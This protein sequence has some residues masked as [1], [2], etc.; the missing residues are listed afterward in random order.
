MSE[1]EQEVQEQETPAEETTEEVVEQEEAP[2]GWTGPSKEE[3]ERTQQY[4]QFVAQQFIADD[5]EPD[6]A[7]QA[8]A[9]LNQRLSYAE[10]AAAIAVEER[11]RAVM[12]EMFGKLE[13]KVGSFDHELAEMYAERL[14]PKYAS[15]PRKAVEE[16]AKMAAAKRKADREAGIQEYTKSLQGGGSDDPDVTNAGEFSAEAPKNYDDVISKWEKLAHQGE[17]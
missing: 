7:Q 6:P 9:H 10:Q 17:V 5:D 8:F 4:L 15:N 1:T 16:G 12:Q 13:E 11:G 2:A 14:A 3:W